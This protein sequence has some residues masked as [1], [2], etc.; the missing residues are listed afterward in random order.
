MIRGVESGPKEAVLDCPKRGNRINS[1]G[2][3]RV[4]ARQGQSDLLARAN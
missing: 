3:N 2:L 4:L 1:E